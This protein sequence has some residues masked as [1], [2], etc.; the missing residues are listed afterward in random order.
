MIHEANH[1]RPNDDGLK[2]GGHQASSASVVSILTALYLRWLRAGRPRRGQAARGRRP[3]TRSQYLLGRL[4]AALP[5]PSCARSVVSS[6]TRAGRR[7]PTASTSRPARSG[8]ARW[9]RCSRLSPTATSAPLPASRP[10]SQPARRFV[11]LV[12]DAE[13]DEGNVWEAI[14]EDVAGRARQRHDDRRPQ[15]PEPRSGRAR[16]PRPSCRGHVRRGRLAGPRGE[17]RAP[18]PGTVR[19]ARAA[20][21]SQR[22]STTW[23][24]EDYQVLIRRPGAELRERL[25]DGAPAGRRDALARRLATSP[26]TTCR[27]PWPTSAGTTSIELERALRGADRRADAPDR[28]S[29]P[30]RSRAGVC[31]SPATAEPL[32][33]ALAP[34]R[35]RRSARDLDADPDDAWAGFEPGSPEA[36]PVAERAARLGLDDAR[37]RPHGSTTRRRSRRRTSGSAATQHPAGL[38]RHARRARPRPDDRWPRIV[39]AAPDV[40]VSTNLGGWINRVG[41]LRQRREPDRHDDTQRPLRLGARAGRPA[42]R[43]RHQR[44]EPVHVAEPVRAWPTSCSASRWRPIG[45]VY[46]PFICR[47][48][49]AL[50]LRPVRQVALPA[51]RDAVGRHARARGR[52]APVDDHAVARHRAAGAP[53]LRAGLRAGGRVEPARGRSAAS[54]T[55][56]DGFATYLRLTTR[57]STSR[58]PT[59][60]ERA[61]GRRRMARAVLAGRLP[62]DR[63]SRGRPSPARRTPGRQG[64]RRRARRHRGRRSGPVPPPTRRSPPTSSS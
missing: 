55:R 27:A 53:L 29:S 24:N 47:G 51:R 37:A 14:L 54:S 56:D 19:A 20:R 2:V 15:P 38:R 49:D 13:L 23:S 50:D 16:D 4:D 41:R 36:P 57:P 32:R 22:G 3:T 8:S 35:S 1:V 39:T 33:D 59:P 63:G 60:V 25:L 18:P 31:R 26:T 46:D 21:P 64:R 58:W 52:G 44:D 10:R 30:T 9:R 12:G 42:H 28:S 61:A 48:L 11:A 40:A 45:T 43:A 7:T 17:V 6:R 5:H 34:T 62:P